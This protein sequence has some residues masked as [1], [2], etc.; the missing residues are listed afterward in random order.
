MAPLMQRAARGALHCAT[1]AT[2]ALTAALGCARQAEGPPDILW[3]V[4]DTV[5]A[6]HLSLHGHERPTTPRLDAWAAGARVY[7]NALSAAPYTLPSHASMFTGLQPGEHC[8]S[9]DKRHLDLERT[10]LAELLRAAGYATYLYSANPHITESKHFTQGF[11]RAE[12]PWSPRFREQALRIVLS[13]LPTEDHSSELPERARDAD[14][15]PWNIKASGELA[16]V[17]LLDWLGSV[18]V[19]R[20]YFAF[21][22]YMEAHRPLIPRR[23]A[24]EQLMTPDEVERSYRIDRSWVP[25][26]EYTFGLREYSDDELEVIRATY[27]ATLRELDDLF[28]DLLAALDAAGRLDDT[29][30][31]LTS[32]HGEHLGEHHM[33]DHQYSIHQVLLHVPLIVHYPARFAPGRDDTPV[34]NFDLFPTLLELAGVALPPD[35]PVH[36]RSL[37]HASDGRI[38]LAEDPSGSTSGL[39][40]VMPLHPGWDPTPWLRTQR[41]LHDG[42]WKFVWR[43]AGAPALYDVERDPEEQHDLFAEP[44]E[45]TR[46]ETLRRT[47]AQTYPPLTPC[48]GDD[49]RTRISP[50]ERE[51]L[52]SLGYVVDEPE[53][54]DDPR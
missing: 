32:D 25:M 30:V 36:A 22:N 44:S 29:V 38:R 37:L 13:K 11:D 10:T 45:R 50:Q 18:D 39:K 21:L 47:L 24:R 33:L 43:S 1:V 42:G 3:V 40:D 7:E 20:P 26:W 46:R 41:A 9:N 19:D 16:Q 48:R 8:T 52:E 54:A 34:M 28:A 6:D 5:R 53:E 23:E 15:G 2:L 35:Q 27:D 14:V 4:W 49:R 31:V 12:H 17:G 51:L